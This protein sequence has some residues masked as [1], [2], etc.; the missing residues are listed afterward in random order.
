MLF[1][2]LTMY[3]GIVHIPVTLHLNTF[4]SISYSWNKFSRFLKPL[5][6]SST[7]DLI[8]RFAPVGPQFLYF[9]AAARNEHKHCKI[10]T[11]Q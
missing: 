9:I 4:T 5:S 7:M 3:I 11:K 8:F 6:L 2:Y 1:K 10:V